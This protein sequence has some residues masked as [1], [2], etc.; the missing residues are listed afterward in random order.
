M[1]KHFDLE[2]QKEVIRTLAGS[3]LQQR[4]AL[5]PLGTPDLRGGQGGLDPSTGINPMPMSPDS[6]P[7]VITVPQ[8]ITLPQEITPPKEEI[9]VPPDLS[10]LSLVTIPPATRPLPFPLTLPL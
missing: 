8:V 6:V 9:T 4:T 7:H 3:R 10:V 2:L 5:Q 1:H